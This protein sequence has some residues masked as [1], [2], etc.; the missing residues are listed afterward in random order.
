MNIGF[1]MKMEI[2]KVCSMGENIVFKHKDKWFFTRLD[3]IE[4]M[5]A[6]SDRGWYFNWRRYEAVMRSSGL[7]GDRIVED[8]CTN[9]SHSEVLCPKNLEEV[10]WNILKKY[11]NL[12]HNG[13]HHKN[14]RKIMY[15]T[16]I[17]G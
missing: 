4:V 10:R 16:W 13:L 5:L 11:K 14:L 6:Y 7:V 8:S 3:D 12:S 9:D 15:G 2:Q 1:M 17:L